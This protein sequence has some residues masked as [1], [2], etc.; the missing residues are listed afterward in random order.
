MK[1]EREQATMEDMQKIAVSVEVNLLTKRARAKGK[2]EGHC[3]RRVFLS[4]SITL[5]G[6]EDA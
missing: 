4:R 2:E 5:E 6:R 3:K 1:R